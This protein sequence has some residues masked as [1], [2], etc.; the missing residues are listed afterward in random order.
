M[1]PAPAL[2]SS[3]L[4]LPASE[5][6]LRQFPP[7]LSLPFTA[8]LGKASWAFW[9]QPHCTPLFSLPLRRPEQPAHSP[10][11][12]TATPSP[13][14]LGQPPGHISWVP[15]L[16]PQQGGGC[17]QGQASIGP[18]PGQG[19]SHAA[20]D[21]RGPDTETPRQR[22]AQTP[23]TTVPD[24]EEETAPPYPPITLQEL[25]RRPGH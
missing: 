11:P 7:R 2:C 24:R 16:P 5:L 1:T 18:G 3:D 22:E 6:L 10:G 19:L 14:C 23:L 17:R 8:F 12:W 20:G 15:L 4:A 13:I 25:Q 21:Q 9:S